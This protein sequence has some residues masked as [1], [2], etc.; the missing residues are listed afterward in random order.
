MASITLAAG[1][2]GTGVSV[3][4]TELNSLAAG[5]A[6][7]LSAAIDN[8]TNLDVRVWFELN[9]TFGT[10]PTANT[11]VDVYLVPLNSDATNYGDYSTTGPVVDPKTYGDSFVA[12]A[13]TTAQRRVTGLIPLRA[14]SFKVGVVNSTNQAFPASGST[15][16]AY[17]ERDAVA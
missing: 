15:I 10:G 17:L 4:T 1:A 13:V 2:G 6:C 5:A 11:T 7:T 8:A 14:R 16:K 3:L 12:R 9:V